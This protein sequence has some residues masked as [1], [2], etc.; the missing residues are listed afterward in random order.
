MARLRTSVTYTPLH[1]HKHRGGLLGISKEFARGA[2]SELLVSMFERERERKRASH[3]G[4]HKQGR[5][6]QRGRERIPSRLYAVIAEPNWGSIP[7][8]S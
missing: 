3:T 6:R 2:Q 4:A 5:G 8:R 1:T 7:E